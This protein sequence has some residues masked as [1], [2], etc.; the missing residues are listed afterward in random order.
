MQQTATWIYSEG[1]QEIGSGSLALFY[2]IVYVHDVFGSVAEEWND[3]SDLTRIAM[4]WRYGG[5]AKSEVLNALA[6]TTRMDLDDINYRRLCDCIQV[7]L[8]GLNHM[9]RPARI[10]ILFCEL[11]MPERYLACEIIPGRALT[12]LRTKQPCPSFQQLQGYPLKHC[13]PDEKYA[14][15]F[16]LR[17]EHFLIRQMK[18]NGKKS[19]LPCKLVLPLHMHAIT[20]IVFQLELNMTSSELL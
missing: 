19:P 2:R 14:M 20:Q 3:C 4:F 5:L 8:A 11:S 7:S 6:T 18:E 12:P 17:H 15:T 10:E 1:S 13:H 16:E 9:V